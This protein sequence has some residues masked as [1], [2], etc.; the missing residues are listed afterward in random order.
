MEFSEFSE[1]QIKS[2]INLLF[3]KNQNISAKKEQSIQ[4]LFIAIEGKTRI[5]GL[6]TAQAIHLYNWMQC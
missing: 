1:E 5:E 4:R 3:E 2:S 6:E